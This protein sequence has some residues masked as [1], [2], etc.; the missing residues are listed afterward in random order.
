MQPGL[1]DPQPVIVP[2]EPE[3]EPEPEPG[4]PPRRPG[5]IPAGPR[6]DT[7]ATA[8]DWVRSIG[9]STARLRP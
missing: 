8:A 5:H 9:R 3:P 6:G 1:P 7:T 2:A 4:P